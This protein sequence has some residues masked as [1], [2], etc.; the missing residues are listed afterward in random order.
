MNNKP[1]NIDPAE[2]FTFE[3]GGKKQEVVFMVPGIRFFGGMAV[4]ILD[5]GIS[6][7]LLLNLLNL[8]SVNPAGF[9][10]GF[11]CTAAI[12]AV[13]N[14]L[15]LWLINIFLSPNKWNYEVDDKYMRLYRKKTVYYFYYTPETKL[16]C[17]MIGTSRK[18]YG[19]L[20]KIT[21]PRDKVFFVLKFP[22]GEHNRTFENTPFGILQQK[23]DEA[24]GVIKPE[25]QPVP[26]QKEPIYDKEY[27]ERFGY[28]KE[29]KP[30][31]YD[32]DIP[33]DFLFPKKGLLEKEYY[34]DP[35][36]RFGFDFGRRQGKFFVIP[37]WRFVVSALVILA[38]A[39]GEFLIV[40]RIV[41]MLTVALSSV[42]LMIFY[43]IFV[44]L[45]LFIVGI[46]LNV[47]LSPQQWDYDEGVKSMRIYRK[48][49]TLYFPYDSTKRKHLTISTPHKIRGMLVTINSVSG[50]IFFPVTFG[51]STTDRTFEASV[52]GILQANIDK[53]AGLK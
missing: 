53:Q 4:I 20:A 18:N 39:A 38:A 41:E 37:I 32:P 49:K 36:N 13:A 33:S 23:I 43:I 5:A 21:T 28:P 47:L 24:S 6:I 51:R 3:F 48:N 7:Y 22:R 1:Y 10:Y 42:Y 19:M 31:D 12:F 16:T 46:L 2:R 30:Q 45:I 15:A 34:V 9:L 50:T 29:Q 25:Q 35:S 26:V 8:L 11:L 40:Y 27:Y 52:F 44:V 17:K 14:F